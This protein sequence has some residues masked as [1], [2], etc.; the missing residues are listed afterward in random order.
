METVSFNEVKNFE[1]NFWSSSLNSFASDL[2]ILSKN[3]AQ[4]GSSNLN[5]DFTASEEV[6]LF[7]TKSTSLQLLKDLSPYLSVVE[8]M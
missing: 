5:N 6:L 7:S 3:G 1:G 8:R 2:N 4:L